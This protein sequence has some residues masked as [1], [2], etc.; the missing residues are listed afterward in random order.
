MRPNHL[1]N[2]C[3]RQEAAVNGWLGIPSSYAAEVMGHQGFD[4]VTVDMQHGMIGFDQAIAM[5]QA[6]SATAGRGRLRHHLPD[7]FLS[8]GS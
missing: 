6:L 8:A 2:M 4:A 1:K 3:Q 7:D 5:L